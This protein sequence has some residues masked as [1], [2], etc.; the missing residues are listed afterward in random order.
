MQEA[1]AISLKS[2]RDAQKR[3][4]K[5][6]SI[7]SGAAALPGNAGCHRSPPGAEIPLLCAHGADPDGRGEGGEHVPLF[8]F[9]VLHPPADQQ[10]WAL[11]VMALG[12][13]Q[14]SP[15]SDI[16]PRGRWAARGALEGTRGWMAGGPC[17]RVRVLCTAV[18]SGWRSFTPYHLAR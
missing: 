10:L 1:R 14:L 12:C 5:P 7:I 16:P 6:G 18:I 17:S 15:N 3:A 9:G 11:P 4:L 13:P 8:W 2:F